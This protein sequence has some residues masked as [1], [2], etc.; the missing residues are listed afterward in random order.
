MAVQ[1]IAR[2]LFIAHALSRNTLR[3]RILGRCRL[4]GIL[5]AGLRIYCADDLR[6]ISIRILVYL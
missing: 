6:G 5:R 1:Q 3:D 4:M 2:D